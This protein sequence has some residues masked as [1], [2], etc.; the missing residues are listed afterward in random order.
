MYCSVLVTKPFDQTF[1]YKLKPDQSV[2]QGNIVLV[3]FGNKNDQIGMVYEVY[4]SLPKNVKKIKLKEVDLVFVNLFFNKKLIKFIDWIA[5]YTLAPKGMV[6]KL[7]LVNKKIIDHEIKKDKMFNFNPINLDLN[8][9]Q[10]KSFNIINKSLVSKYHPFV[11]EGVTGSGKTEVYFK[12]IEKILSQK[13][14]A[15]ILLPEISLTPQLEKRFKYRFGFS[16]DIWHSKV[17]EK[18]RKNTRF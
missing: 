10:Q 16:P 18:N 1:I 14:Q 12:A 8:V 17:T 4:K 13:K 3:P 2:T 6:L 7:F 11:L 9:V 5:D 15:L